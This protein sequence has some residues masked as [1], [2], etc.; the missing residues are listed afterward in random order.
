M[1]IT[2]TMPQNQSCALLDLQ[3]DVLQAESTA[4][5]SITI[6]GINDSQSTYR[7]RVVMVALS[8]SSQ[9]LD[10]RSR[11]DFIYHGTKYPITL[12]LIGPPKLI[13]W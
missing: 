13:H 5:R 11:G 2:K 7:R 6:F 3:S 10:V 1:N 8:V 4:I 12:N 9:Q